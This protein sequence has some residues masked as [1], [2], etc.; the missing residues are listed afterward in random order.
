VLPKS[1]ITVIAP[2]WDQPPLYGRALV[3]LRDPLPADGDL[4]SAVATLSVAADAAVKDAQS[5]ENFK[6]W[7]FDAF[8]VMRWPDDSLGCSGVKV[9]DSN[10]VEG[11]VMF[12][13]KEGLPVSRELEYHTGGGR[14]VFCGFSR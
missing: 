6:A 14:T 2:P 12:L 10:P 3:D 7:D 5:R 8:G 9:S 4:A 11:Y 1:V 13:V